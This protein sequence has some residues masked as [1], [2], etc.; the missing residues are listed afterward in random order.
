MDVVAARVG[1]LR[2]SV[3]QE[4][5]G[6]EVAEHRADVP[7]YS[8]HSAVPDD[9]GG[10][11]GDGRGSHPQSEWRKVV[12]GPRTSGVESDLR[13]VVLSPWAHRNMWSLVSHINLCGVVA[14]TPRSSP[15]RLRP[16]LP[17]GRLG[18][19]DGC[20]VQPD[21]LRGPQPLRVQRDARHVHV[22]K[23]VQNDPYGQLDPHA[24]PSRP[25][26]GDMGRRE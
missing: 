23:E 10:R 25:G 20:G 18:R 8:T 9:Q 11:S 14:L 17:R 16:P 22:R 15:A 12:H 24:P 21:L 3:V 19:V 4:D 5:F 7:P 13:F 2:V 6:V 26:E 1:F